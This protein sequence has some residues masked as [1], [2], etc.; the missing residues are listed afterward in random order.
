MSVVAVHEAG[1]AVATILEGG[2]LVEVNLE[3]YGERDG[4]SA[5]KEFPFGIYQCMEK[6]L[7]VA[8]AGEAAEALYCNRPLRRSIW[9]RDVTHPEYEAVGDVADALECARALINFEKLANFRTSQK[10][11]EE[12]IRILK[13]PRTERRQATGRIGVHLLCQWSRRNVETDLSR[14]W[15]AVSAVAKELLQRRKLSHADVVRIMTAA[16][17]V[18]AR[19]IRAPKKMW[20]RLGHAIFTRKIGRLRF[21]RFGRDWEEEIV[22]QKVVEEKLASHVSTETL[23][24]IRAQERDGVILLHVYVPPRD[25]GQRRLRVTGCPAGCPL[26]PLR[27]IRSWDGTTGG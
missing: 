25:R 2:R 16:S 1:H 12:I 9:S 6:T 24:K 17:P 3:E 14:H 22:P 13:L 10:E 26:E 11:R 5:H 21:R 20:P 27:E 18:T 7:T 19:E 23:K 15:D 8:L 4:V